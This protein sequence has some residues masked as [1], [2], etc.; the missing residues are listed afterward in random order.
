MNNLIE[1]TIDI[2]ETVKS[3]LEKINL[4]KKQFVIVVS[5]GNSFEGIITDGD[6][7]RGVLNGVSADDKLERIMNTNPIFAR[8]TDI[9]SKVQLILK[10]NE[11]KQC[12]VINDKR[13]L[14]NIVYLYEEDKAIK[15]EVV[16]MAGGLGKRMLPLTT[17][18]PKALVNFN[19]Q[20]MLEKIILDLKRSGFK[21]IHISVNYKAEMIKEYFGSG[22]DLDL[23]ISYI[24]EEKKLGTAGSLSLI[25]THLSEPFLVM[26]CD[27]ITEIDYLALLN[28]HKSN[29]SVATMC[30]KDYQ[31]VVP[32]GVVEKQDNKIVS[33]DEKPTK[34]YYVNAGIYVLNP[35]VLK[36]IPFNNYYEMTDLFRELIK[37]NMEPRVFPV[38]EKW[39]DL[40]SVNDINKHI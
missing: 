32:Y 22:N 9:E 26:N 37:K 10:K 3:V 33:L 18:R 11:I 20:P 35:E 17:E 5:K 13:E 40:A 39:Q 14:V 28:F 21:K 34:M 4:N 38:F 8:S 36:I 2:N 1:V 30:V 6:I 29:S 23:E 31:H 16:L 7:R 25:D 12:P 27:L 19:G 24:C 15:N